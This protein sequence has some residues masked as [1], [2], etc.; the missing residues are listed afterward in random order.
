MGKFPN[1]MVTMLGDIEPVFSPAHNKGTSIRSGP[2][3]ILLQISPPHAFAAVIRG[4][5]PPHE[6]GAP[7]G[8]SCPLLSRG[9]LFLFRCNHKYALATKLESTER[10]TIV[11]D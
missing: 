7:S 4:Q 6:S 1:G 5:T 3:G 9:I 10:K 11:Q 2:M 8:I